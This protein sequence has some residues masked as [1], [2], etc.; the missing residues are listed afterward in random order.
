MLNLS[1]PIAGKFP[2]CYL[3]LVIATRLETV[4]FQDILKLKKSNLM[5]SVSAQ[6]ICDFDFDDEGWN[7]N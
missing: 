1:E 4:S 6:W 7:Y 3:W 5:S 2:T